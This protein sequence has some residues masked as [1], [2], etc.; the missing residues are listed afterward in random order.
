MSNVTEEN[1]ELSYVKDGTGNPMKAS[2]HDMEFTTPDSRFYMMRV[3]TWVNFNKGGDP[4]GPWCGHV[5]YVMDMHVMVKEEHTEEVFNLN[6]RDLDVSSIQGQMLPKTSYIGLIKYVNNYG[7]T[8]ELEARLVSGQLPCQR[9]GWLDF[10]LILKEVVAS[11]SSSQCTRTPPPTTT[12][13]W[14]TPEPDDEHLQWLL[15]DDLRFVL[16]R[17]CILLTVSGVRD[18]DL[19]KYKGKVVRTMPLSKRKL[20]PKHNKVVVSASK[21]GRVKQISIEAKNLK[22]LKPIID[23]MQNARSGDAHILKIRAS[24]LAREKS[25][26]PAIDLMLQGKVD[27]GFNHPVLSQMILPIDYLK[28]FDRNPTSIQVKIN[29]GDEAYLVM[30]DLSPSFLY[31][32]PNEYDPEDVYIRYMRGYYLIRARFAITSEANWSA[33]D[34]LFDYKVFFNMIIEIFNQ[35]ED[36]KQDTIQWWNMEV[37][38]NKNGFKAKMQAAKCRAAKLSAQ[39]NAI[40]PTEAHSPTP[41]SAQGPFHPSHVLGNDHGDKDEGGDED[42]QDR[43][44]PSCG[45]CNSSETS[46]EEGEYDHSDEDRAGPLHS[47]R[48]SK[49]TSDEE[50]DLRIYTS[51]ALHQNC[52]KRTRPA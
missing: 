36:W 46:T 25:T 41:P 13:V 44:E 16:E 49:G 24:D 4:A 34:G 18:G 9:V 30:V 5:V 35:D 51:E 37:F 19:A 31:E 12:P 50:D 52:A 8:V 42:E 21:C 11:G 28:D 6:I 14:L 29:G 45:K 39:A 2:I 40:E 32:D 38:G 26:D 48:N 1:N 47:K 20:T 10:T 15:S 27:R 3:G 43:A 17:R 23:G 33:M 7:L 22:P